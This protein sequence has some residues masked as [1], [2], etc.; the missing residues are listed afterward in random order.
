MAG[1]GGGAWKVAYADFVTA[2]MAFFMVMWLVGQKEDVKEAIARYF[3][4]PYGE[5]EPSDGSLEDAPYMPGERKGKKP[6]RHIPQNDSLDPET[7][8]PRVLTIHGGERT[9]VGTL[10]VF[11]DDSV[12]L[13]DQAKQQIDSIV[14]K[15]IGMPQKIEVRGHASR[16]PVKING[17]TP[18]PWELS[19]ER[20]L[21]VME[22]LEQQGIE[23]NRMR[24]TQAGVHEPYTIRGDAP[25]QPRNSRVEIFLL[26]EIAEELVGT[27][28]ERS[29]RYRS[30]ELNPTGLGTLVSPPS[31]DGH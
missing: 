13:N 26:A 2:M 11:A 29:Q 15:L 8:K 7:R 21:A 22:Y 30:D 9:A 28:E 3:E 6:H 31:S 27:P 10:V 19:Y 1:K 4:N 16:R 12:A 23:P 24:L 18:N 25:T 5:P 17:E 14:D 20:C